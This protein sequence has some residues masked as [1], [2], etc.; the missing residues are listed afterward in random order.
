M[1]SFTFKKLNNLVGWLVFLVALFTFV[2]TLEPTVSFWD[3]GEYI[4]TSVNLSIGH[5]PG[6]PMYQMLGAF[7]AMFASD[8]THVAYM[9]NMMSAI[10]SAFTILFLFWTISLLARKMVTIDK[11]KVFDSTGLAVV[12]S[13]AIG[14]LTF[15]FS[16]SFW[17]NAV[18][19]EVY[20]MSSFVTASLFWL[21]LKWEENFD[22]PRGNMW[23][24]LISFV[25][26][27][28]FGVHLLS[29]LVIPA[30]VFVFYFKKYKTITIPQ[31]I[32][33]NILAVLV[34]AFVFKFLFPYTLVFFSASELFFVNTVGLPFNSGTIIA[35]LILIAAFVFGLKYTRK[36]SLVTANTAILCVL[37]TMI[38]FSSWM[39]IPIR[40][41]ANT[42]INENNP[43]SARELLAY[44]N[45]E[46]Y[47]DANVFYG[48]YYNYVY[49]QELDK[50]EPYIDDKPKYE[51]NEKTGKYVIVNNYENAKPNFS[52]KYKGFM[53]RMTNPAAIDN[54][55]AI[56]GIPKNA[57]RKPTFGEN[58]KYMI[59]YQF[60]Y[61]YVRYFMWN[62]VGKQNDI[63][64]R[65]DIH[66][67]NWLTGIN[68]IDSFRLG[69]QSNLPDDV[70]NNKG[71]NTY[72]GLPLILG[73]IGLLFHLKR[74][75][76]DFYTLFI[77]FIFM[78][79]A[80]VFYVNQKAFEPR[81]RDYSYVG[82]FYVFAIWVGFGVLAIYEQFK[83]KMPKKALAIGTTLV[84]LFLVPT[85][86]AKENWNDHNRANRY[87][88]LLNAKAYLDSCQE[89]AILFSIGDNDTFP[90]WYMQEV[91]GYRRDVK[92]IN[93]S[94]FATDWYIDQMKR[95]T[96]TA[97]PIPSSLT[98]DQY[99]YGSLEIAYHVPDPR[100][101]DSIMTL[102]TFMK[103]IESKNRGT[104]IEEENGHMEKAYPVN[105]IRIPVDKQ[106]VLEHHIVP[107]K[108]SA[109]IVPYI[110]ITI[111]DRGI[112][113][114]RILMLDIINNNNW[115]RPIYF[116]G[117]ASAAEE[118]IWM[119]DY[120]QLDGLAFKLVP[121][122]TPNKG[123]ILTMGR[124][125]SESLYE[126]VK[127]WDW[128]NITD[129]NIYLDPESRRN[130]INFRTVMVRLADQFT[131]ENKKKEAEAILDLSLEKMPVDKFGHYSLLLGY[132]ESYYIL[133]KKEKA[134]ALAD[135]LIEK[136]QQNLE[137]YSRFDEY[138]INSVFD[139]METN[140][141]LYN[142]LVEA[143]GEYDDKEY[144]SEQQDEF[145]KYM[146]ILESKLNSVQ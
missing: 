124:I 120:L 122:Y 4:S 83:N 67:G 91:E 72:Y 119:K 146:Q 31:F 136:C 30:V 52:S 118:Y 45:R 27:L 112:Y 47:G 3:S 107:E 41:N 55:K 69:T 99:K 56:A 10:A 97:P 131:I 94:L 98:H 51:K 128:R 1:N 18:E 29:L 92:V 133:G 74:N 139:E 7:F 32:I 36:K 135:K 125:D 76:K 50:S 39:M 64:G 96:F 60:S 117:G 111:D 2:S 22:K 17:F 24:L 28:S 61:M 40:A 123:S 84:C 144:A 89:N 87:T 134:R 26:G 14:A 54:Y 142:T 13:A 65:L 12:G 21:A 38:G 78:S 37:F 86:M 75:P 42:T 53:P 100:V 81:E 71:R 130:S 35:G 5:P 145:V 110:D 140:I 23:I 59:S 68:A 48:K 6:S 11:D 93:S 34:L 63:Q 15:T 138:F 109:K 82:S 16:D 126:K 57:I 66:N 137:Y 105:R 143:I 114:N 102:N 62:F 85:L 104:Y 108:D 113:K 88:A 141:V 73:L 106:A 121:I 9:V 80:I 44:Y 70:K 101:K 25:I 58:L 95:Q 49:G 79:L 33:G 103:W 132:V 19:A 46:Q 43:S 129:D 115:E 127:K 116:T 90:L 8:S 20:A 77:F